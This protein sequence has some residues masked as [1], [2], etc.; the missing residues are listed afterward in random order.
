MRQHWRFFPHPA[1]KLDSFLLKS[2][3]YMNVELASRFFSHFAKSGWLD[4]TSSYRRWALAATARRCN[5][6]P[7]AIWKVPAN[8][9]RGQNVRCE[10]RACYQSSWRSKRGPKVGMSERFIN[11]HGYCARLWMTDLQVV[12]DRRDPLFPTSVL[13]R[14]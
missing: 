13:Y 4:Q 1:S 10:L 2:L 5:S 8:R 7:Q 3:D 14:V 12:H 11:F 6:K 9:Q